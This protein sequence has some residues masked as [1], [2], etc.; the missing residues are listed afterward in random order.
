MMQTL[1]LHWVDISNGRYDDTVKQ[2]MPT[3]ASGM[4]FVFFTSPV[5]HFVT[6][7]RKVDKQFRDCGQ[8]LVEKTDNLLGKTIKGSAIEA[9]QCIV[10]MCPSSLQTSKMRGCE[11]VKRCIPLVDSA[12]WERYIVLPAQQP[13]P[14]TTEG[15]VQWWKVR[16]QDFPTLAPVCIAYLLAPRSAAQ[17]GKDGNTS[18]PSLSVQMPSPGTPDRLFTSDVSPSKHWPDAWPPAPGVTGLPRTP[19]QIFLMF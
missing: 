12:E 3:S 6:D 5:P 7:A 15:R 16:L 13:A 17:A 14:T 10:A 19:L 1:K 9:S 18:L 2:K 4:C 11:M 8:A